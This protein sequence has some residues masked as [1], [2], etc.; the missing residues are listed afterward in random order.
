MCC[1]VIKSKKCKRELTHFKPLFIRMSSRWTFSGIRK[2]EPDVWLPPKEMPNK[3]KKF[4]SKKGRVGW[5]LVQLPP[6]AMEARYYRLGDYSRRVSSSMNHV[7]SY[8]LTLQDTKKIIAEYGYGPEDEEVAGPFDSHNQ[9]MQLFEIELQTLQDHWQMVLDILENKKSNMD[10]I[11]KQDRQFL[12]WADDKP[13]Y[14]TPSMVNTSDHYCL[15]AHL[16]ERQEQLLFLF[17]HK[18]WPNESDRAACCEEMHKD[19]HEDLESKNILKHYG[20]MEAWLNPHP[21]TK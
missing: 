1:H 17:H 18:H 9:D 5:E 20:M 4:V 3:T 15:V 7:R 6:L 21:N 11:Q 13:E 2:L 10:G 16:I 12:K 19:H 14:L 8:L